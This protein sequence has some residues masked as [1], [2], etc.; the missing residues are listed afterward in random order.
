[1]KLITIL[2]NLINEGSSDILYHYV[3]PTYILEIIENNRLNTIAAMGS[4][5]D[6]NLNKNKFYYLSTT[7]SRSSGYKKYMENKNNETNR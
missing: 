5:T 2:E 1:M 7:R 4:D 3:D 6:Y